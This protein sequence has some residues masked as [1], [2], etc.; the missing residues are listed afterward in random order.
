MILQIGKNFLASLIIL[1][2]LEIKYLLD[3]LVIL[4]FRLLHIIVRI[5]ESRDLSLPIRQGEDVFHRALIVDVRIH[6]VLLP[7]LFDLVI[8]V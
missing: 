4:F 5:L 2:R 3:E 7:Q 6:N 1:R 8:I